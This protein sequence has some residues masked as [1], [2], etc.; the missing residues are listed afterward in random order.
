MELLKCRYNNYY[1]HHINME[2]PQ[3]YLCSQTI[4]IIYYRLCIF[5]DVIHYVIY[6]NRILNILGCNN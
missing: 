2:K 4:I 1:Y 6:K 3:V 5:P